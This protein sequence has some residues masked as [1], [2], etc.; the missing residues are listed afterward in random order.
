LFEFLIL[1]E[2]FGSPP[3]YLTALSSK[4][5]KNDLQFGAVAG[6]FYFVGGR[7]EFDRGSFNL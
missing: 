6:N 5:G 3:E 1:T 2:I 4:I 7:A